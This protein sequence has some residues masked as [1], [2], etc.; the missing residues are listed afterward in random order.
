[1]ATQKSRFL[2]RNEM[3]PITG[4]SVPFSYKLEKQGRFPKRVNL[5]PDPDGK[6][7]T[8]WVRD[9]VEAWVEDR[10]KTA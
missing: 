2:K 6:P 5:N 3:T 8:R 4:I 9:E 7:V 1:M 10:L